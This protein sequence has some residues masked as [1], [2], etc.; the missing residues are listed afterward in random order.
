MA[1]GGRL[2]HMRLCSNIAKMYIKALLAIEESCSSNR[3][4]HFMGGWERIIL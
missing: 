3:K 1:V 4:I 2:F